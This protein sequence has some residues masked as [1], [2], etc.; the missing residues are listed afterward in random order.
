MSNSNECGGRD[1]EATA[2]NML[3]ESVTKTTCFLTNEVRDVITGMNIIE[4]LVQSTSNPT[5]H[6]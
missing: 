3:E 6:G 1:I 5:S 4:Q 2:I